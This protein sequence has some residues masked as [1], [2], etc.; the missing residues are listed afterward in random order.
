MKISLAVLVT[1]GAVLSAKAATAAWGCY[2]PMPGHP[3]EAE[4]QSFIAE[5][6]PMA[7]AAERQ[8]GVPAAALAGMAIVESGYGWTR[9][10]L[11]ANNLF[12]WKYYSSGSAGGRAAYVLTCQPP[13]DVNN[14]YVHFVD[15][16]DAIDFVATRLATIAA[17]RADTAAYV[18]ARAR[19]DD[20]VAAVDAWLAG[21][22]DP[23]N[24][25]PSEYVR[26]V[27]RMMND[28]FMPSDTMSADRSLYRLSQTL[29]AASEGRAMADSD[30]PYISRAK[31]LYARLVG[32]GYMEKNCRP[33]D[34][35]PDG[36]AGFPV[37]RCEYTELG[38]AAVVHL[39]DADA[40]RL[41]AWTVSACR[42]AGATQIDRCIDVV[43]DQIKGASGTQFPV[44]GYVIEPAHAVGGHGNG[45]MC[46]LF[47]DGV[48]IA[49]QTTDTRAPVSGRC[50]PDEANAEPVMRAKT[51]ARIASTTREQYRQAGGTDEVGNSASR[52][53]R[54]LATVRRLYQQA[55]SSPRNELISA[56]AISA[57]KEGR[58]R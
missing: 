5:I 55:W 37:Q 11:E 29:P 34:L 16:A 42:D 45:P 43:F 49:T 9:T 2:D 24:W 14:R 17:Y 7:I 13:E 47:R 20:P 38:A 39:L 33:T 26:T 46:A 48:T 40:D 52:D 6:S 30:G 44:A 22:A 21:I 35:L 58:F 4:R 12:G 31:A 8:H 54:W 19:G 1:A 27:R 32:Q 53:V 56:W 10:A 23:Y 57:K 51:Y 15:R 28:P 41:A 25:K 3:T 36:W 50:G 18:Q